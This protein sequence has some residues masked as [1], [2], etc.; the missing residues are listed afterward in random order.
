MDPSISLTSQ[1]LK[2]CPCFKVPPFL[3][4]EKR[5]K[6]VLSVAR[7]GLLGHKREEVPHYLYIPVEDHEDY[8]IDKYFDQTFDFIEKARKETNV[9]IHCMVGVSRSVT[10]AIAYLLKKYKYTLGQVISLIQRKRR[11]VV[12]LIR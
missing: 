2:T 7:S 5:I 12:F 4:Q 11:K 1:L 3:Y 6:A 8:Q 10:I 9:L